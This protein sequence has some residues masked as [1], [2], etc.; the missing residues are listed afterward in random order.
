MESS[1][2]VVANVMECDIVVN[3]FELQEFY[4][5]YFHFQTNTIWERYELPYLSSNG[6]NRSFIRMASALNNP[7][8][9]I[10]H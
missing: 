3:E 7:W 2:V 9:L 8:K 4:R 6:L 5:Y 10:C 1:R